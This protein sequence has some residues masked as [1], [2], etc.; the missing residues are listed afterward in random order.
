M[1]QEGEGELRW[2]PTNLPCALPHPDTCRDPRREEKDEVE[3]YHQVDEANCSRWPTIDATDIIQYERTRQ[4]ANSAP[5][6][7]ASQSGL[8][9]RHPHRPG[10][11]LLTMWIPCVKHPPLGVV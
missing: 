11:T 9:T 4:E 1:L 3:R 2:G 5:T 7:G 10:M 8:V 6:Q